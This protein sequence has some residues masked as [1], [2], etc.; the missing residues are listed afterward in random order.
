MDNDQ[1][2]VN[3]KEQTPVTPGEEYQDS[4]AKSG[5][6]LALLFALSV[7]GLSVLPFLASELELPSNLLRASVEALPEEQVEPAVPR[8]PLFLRPYD[9]LTLQAEA[10]VVFDLATHKML[11][12]KNAHTP[13]ALASVTK[14]M[15]AL[16]AL[17]GSVSGRTISVSP[18]A[19][20]TEGD[21]GLYVGETWKRD[22]LLAYTMVTSSNDGAAALAETIGA[23]FTDSSDARVQI[24]AFVRQMNERAHE[25]GMEKS[26]FNN[27]TGLDID[28]RTSGA[29]GSAYD[30]AL[31]LEALLKTQA[32]VLERLRT[33]GDHYVSQ[34]GFAHHATNTSD[35]VLS[36]SGL[37]LTKTGYTDIAGGNL[38]VLFDA[39]IGHPIAVVVL[40][41]TIDG[42]FDDVSTLVQQT[43]T[44]LTSGWYE[45]D[46]E[47]EA[48]TH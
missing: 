19:L 39:G 6:V 5:R 43:R 47:L 40:G 46:N 28:A 25:L 41:S 16:V 35:P 44:Y 7:S 26:V 8:V 23:D 13:L 32:P 12:A 15:T 29:Y 36:T 2:T 11:Y 42:R 1:T 20:S 21:S 17:E 37:D 31:L 14:L 45:Y 30:V 38:A 9:G 34:N 24:D 22:D 27:P 48:A 4:G 10:A 3:L 33:S 18:T